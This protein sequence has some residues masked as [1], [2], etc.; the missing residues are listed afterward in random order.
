MWDVHAWHQQQIYATQGNPRTWK[1][2]E[3]VGHG[4]SPMHL[5][6]FIFENL[7]AHVV[8]IEIQGGDISRTRIYGG[9]PILGDNAAGIPVTGEFKDVNGDGKVDMIAHVGNESFV[10]LNDGTQFKPQQQLGGAYV[11]SHGG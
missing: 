8:I 11:P 5:S 7:N 3:V 4:D 10:Y 2:D 9:I 6:H 1:V